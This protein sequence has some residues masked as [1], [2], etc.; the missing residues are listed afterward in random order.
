[1]YFVDVGFDVKEWLP[2]FFLIDSLCMRGGVNVY[3]SPASRFVRGG[4]FVLVLLLYTHAG[5]W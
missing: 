3:A 5:D 4:L 2:L 1:M